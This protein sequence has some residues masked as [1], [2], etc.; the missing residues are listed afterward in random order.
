MISTCRYP[1]LSDPSESFS[2][3]FL[4]SPHWYRLKKNHGRLS[5]K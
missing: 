5:E 2:H 3:L 1:K 4:V